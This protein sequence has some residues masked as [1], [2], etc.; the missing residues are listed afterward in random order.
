LEFLGAT[1]KVVR[2]AGKVYFVPIYKRERIMSGLQISTNPLTPDEEL[3]KAYSLLRLGWMECYQDIVPYI[4]YLL[5]NI[6]ESSVKQSFLR[7]GIPSQQALMLE[8]A[9]VMES[10]Y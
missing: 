6:P 9:G 1:A 10:K 8:W 3:M 2:L 5:R 7:T 4:H